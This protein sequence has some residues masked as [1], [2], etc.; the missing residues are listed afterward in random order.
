MSKLRI[1]RCKAYAAMRGD[2]PGGAG[3]SE[4]DLMEWSYR[5]EK[6]SDG[7]RHRAS[8]GKM[9]LPSTGKRTELRD[10]DKVPY[11]SR[12]VDN[13][14]VE[15]KSDLNHYGSSYLRDIRRGG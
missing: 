4:D 14:M 2:A 10:T 13:V 1:A 5:A 7:H 9:D 11:R 3:R 8:D 15:G 12:K 6:N